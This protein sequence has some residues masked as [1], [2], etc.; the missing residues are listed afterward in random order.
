MES[1]NDQKS[2]NFVRRFLLSVGVGFLGFVIS[3]V[4]IPVAYWLMVWLEFASDVALISAVFGWFVA[5]T[6]GFLWSEKEPLKQYLWGKAIAYPLA[7]II[8]GLAWTLKE[9]WEWQYLIGIP[10][11]VLV[12]FPGIFLQELS[13]VIICY[14]LYLKTHAGGES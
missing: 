13:E 12:H 3:L 1:T 4:L 5:V 11:S 14:K 2:R 10:L 8:F 7:G 9:N 6:M